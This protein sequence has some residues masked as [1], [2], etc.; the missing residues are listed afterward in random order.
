M[1]TSRKLGPLRVRPHIR[2]GMAT[3]KWFVDIPASLTGNGRR[4]RKLFDNQRTALEMARALRRRLDPVA[5]SV[6]TRRCGVRFQEVIERWRADETLRVATLKKRA[7]TLTTDLYRLRSIAAFLGDDDIG[8][9][10]ERRLVEYQRSRLELGRKPSTIN[11]EI[12]TLSVVLGWARKQ[13]LIG[14]VPRVEQV[15]IRREPAVILSP[16]EVVR[17]I[18]YLPPRLQPLVHFMA[19]TGCRRGEALNL[20]WDCVD[21]VNGHV[22][23]RSRDG[24]T[25]KTQSSERRIPL[26]PSLLQ[27]IRRLPKEG[28][29]V[30]SGTSPDRPLG[31]FRRSWAT[32]VQRAKITRNGQPVRI[33]PH[34]LRKAHATWLAMKGVPPSVLQDLLGHARGSRVTDRYYVF[35]TEEAKRAAVIELPIGEQKRNERVPDLAKSGNKG[36]EGPLRDQSITTKPL[37]APR[38]SGG[39]RGKD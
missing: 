7:S 10:S 25:P 36:Q 18:Q 17:I 14:E 1:T 34:G 30:F 31:E 15:P 3:G 27:V 22:E 20:T 37:G 26:G 35:A 5:G 8:A 32:S 24:W 38:G 12:G 2:N 13:G 39:G 29:Y 6:D 21:E 11:S 19:E 16:E 4:K 33:T 9:I 23:I 28:P